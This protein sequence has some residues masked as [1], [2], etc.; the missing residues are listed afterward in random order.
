MEISSLEAHIAYSAGETKTPNV[1]TGARTVIDLL[2]TSGLV[3]ED[4]DRII[5][6]EIA[7]GEETITTAEKKSAPSTIKVPTTEV[8]TQ[9]DV[10]LNIE[11]HIDAKPSELDGLGE[12]L[13]ALIKTLSKGGSGEEK[14]DKSDEQK[15]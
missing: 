4:N 6:V 10:S 5:P 14:S 13:N 2:L 11:V 3:R 1:M 9:P 8:T 15:G 12:K 7:L